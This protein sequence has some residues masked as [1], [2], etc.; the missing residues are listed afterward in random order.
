MSRALN[1]AVSQAEVRAEATRK[2]ARIT[3]IEPLHPAGTRV[4]FANSVDA[5]SVAR[6][7]KSKILAGAVVRTPLRTVSGR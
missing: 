2:G 5:A 6:S 3:A 7:F 4:V 1:L